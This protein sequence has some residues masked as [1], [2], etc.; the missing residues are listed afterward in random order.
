MVAQRGRRAET[1]GLGDG[2]E[3]SAVGILQQRAGAP[4]PLGEKPGA[5]GETRRLH[6]PALKGALAH[7]GSGRQRRNAVRLIERRAQPIDQRGEPRGLMRA[8][9][10]RGHELRLPPSL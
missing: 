7:A 4:P 8:R 3:T 9:H 10:R 6:E 2:V 5:G 1:A